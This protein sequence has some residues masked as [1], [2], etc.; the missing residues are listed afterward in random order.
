MVFNGIDTNNR[1]VWNGN[2]VFTRDTICNSLEMCVRAKV[3]TVTTA[4]K[5]GGRQT[6]NQALGHLILI[7]MNVHCLCVCVRVFS[8]V[9]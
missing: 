9:Q 6:S 7:T 1:S 8:L 5:Q 3:V 2:S 4:S